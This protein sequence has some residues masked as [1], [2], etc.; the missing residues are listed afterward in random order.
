MLITDPKDPRLTHGVDSE[1]GP[2]ADVYLVMSEDERK[3]GWV[4][5]LRKTYIHNGIRRDDS[6]LCGVATTMATAIAETYA[7]NPDYYGATYCVGCR[8]HLPVSEFTWEDGNVVG[9]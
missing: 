9:S 6:D 2:Q 8:M 4:R 1:P 3:R 5:P 7:K